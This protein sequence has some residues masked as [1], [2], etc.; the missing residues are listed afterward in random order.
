MFVVG[1]YIRNDLNLPKTLPDRANYPTNYA[2]DTP[3]TNL[4]VFESKLTGEALAAAGVKI[5]YVFSSPALRSVQTCDNVL[6]GNVTSLLILRVSN[7]LKNLYTV[8]SDK[9]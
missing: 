5:K 4:G 8:L 3:I 2:D 6:Q 7:V 9:H 1:K